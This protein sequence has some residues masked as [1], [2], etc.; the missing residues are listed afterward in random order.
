MSVS[1]YERLGSV[2]HPSLT[3]D[4]YDTKDTN[5]PC[6][7]ALS[8]SLDHFAIA[9]APGKWLVDFFPIRKFFEKPTEPD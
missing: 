6:I 2:P 4:G 1:I 9:A 5:D 3:L 8:E 7:A